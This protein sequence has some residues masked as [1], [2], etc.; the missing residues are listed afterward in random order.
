MQPG[1]FSLCVTEHAA[2]VS[3]FKALFFLFLRFILTD[4]NCCIVTIVHGVSHAEA[5]DL[6]MDSTFNIRSGLHVCT[7]RSTCGF[8]WCF[9]GEWVTVH[10]PSGVNTETGQTNPQKYI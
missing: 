4:E 1:S 9:K 7:S 5:L 10:L 2:E 6:V 3:A 8:M